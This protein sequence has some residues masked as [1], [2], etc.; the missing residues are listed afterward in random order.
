MLVYYKY[1][2]VHISA[3]SLFITSYNF[4]L[5][6]DDYFAPVQLIKALGK[7]RKISTPDPEIKRAI[8]VKALVLHMQFILLNDAH[9]CIHCVV[10][11][12]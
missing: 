10:G 7:L 5:L 3:N 1:N 9:Y 11:E 2:I 4:E 6:P 8:Q 12:V